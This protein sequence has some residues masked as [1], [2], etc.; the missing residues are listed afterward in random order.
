MKVSSP[1]EEQIIVMLSMTWPR[2]YLY[3]AVVNISS[4]SAKK[5]IVFVKNWANSVSIYS[6]IVAKQVT[7]FSLTIDVP[8]YIIV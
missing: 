8:F 1:T 4:Y 3:S 2:N 6:A 7:A 5:V